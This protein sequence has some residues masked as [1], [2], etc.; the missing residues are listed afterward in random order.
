[1]SILGASCGGDKAIALAVDSK[2]IVAL[3]FLSS[4]LST[5]SISNLSTLHQVPMLFIA[6]KGDK[7]AYEASQKSIDINQSP[8]SKFF[9][10]SG[11]DHGYPLFETDR[12]LE[13]KIVSW[14][15]S[16]VA[17]NKPD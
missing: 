5:R 10:Y 9:P 7:F 2:E 15:S 17:E 4:R 13:E 3:G 11:R 14:F 8:K 16:I 1:V 6:A 12:E